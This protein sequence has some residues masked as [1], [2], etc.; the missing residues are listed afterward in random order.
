MIEIKTNKCDVEILF[1]G[2]ATNILAEIA[3][4]QTIL[5][6]HY[7]K[8]FGITSFRTAAL[9]ITNDLLSIHG[10]DNIEVQKL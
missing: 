7:A 6:E 3:A 2:K 8:I 10:N 5:I 9:Q 1:R 4:T